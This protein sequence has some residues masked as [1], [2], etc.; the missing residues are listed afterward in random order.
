MVIHHCLQ[1]LPRLRIRYLLRHN[2]VNN[3]KLVQR[4]LPKMSEYQ[5]LRLY[6]LQHWQMAFRWLHYLLLL[7]GK[8]FPKYYNRSFS[9]RYYTV[10]IR[11]Q[12]SQDNHR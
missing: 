11:V 8:Y 1:I 12:K 3:I 7:I 2:H 10:G 5:W 9:K 4:N 6:P